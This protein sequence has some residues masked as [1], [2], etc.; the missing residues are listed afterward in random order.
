MKRTAD[1]SIPI[2]QHVAAHR[3]TLVRQ[4]E[5]LPALAATRERL[6]RE[7][8]GG[9]GRSALRRTTDAAACL[10]KLDVQIERLESNIRDL[11]D[12]R[13]EADRRRLEAEDAMRSAQDRSDTEVLALTKRIAALENDLATAVTARHQAEARAAAA[14]AATESDVDELEID[15]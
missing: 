6:R 3:E 4:K 15:D 11:S 9:S 8:E 5:R 13:K 10:A 2:A 14:W 7:A 1:S 12:A